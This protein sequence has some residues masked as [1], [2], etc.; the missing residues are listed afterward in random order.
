MKGKNVLKHK[1]ITEIN[2][3]L[4]A[5]I[6]PDV[7]SKW[8]KKK[9]GADKMMYISAV[10]LTAYRNNFLKLGKEEL[11]ERRYELESKR[12][13]GDVNAIDTFTAVKEFTEAKKKITTEIVNVLDNFGTIQDEIRER[14]AVFKT[15]TVDDNGDP[16][17]NPRNEEVFLGYLARLESMNNSFVKA[18]NEMKKQEVAAGGNTDIK[19]TVHEM[20]KYAEA[21]KNILQRIFIELDPAFLPQAIAIYT[22]EI[23]QLEGQSAEN[24]LNI[25]INS[26]QGAGQQIDITTAPKPLPQASEAKPEQDLEKINIIDV[27]SKEIQYP[28]EK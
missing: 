7:V 2:E 14:M 22:E 20:N 25:S 21:F 17:W 8:L 13:T 1:D 15:K 26:S 3:Q 9:W 11:A 19:I 23:A 28:E 4:T 24:A 5:G 6:L 18:V 16:V 10:T 12:Q 27:D